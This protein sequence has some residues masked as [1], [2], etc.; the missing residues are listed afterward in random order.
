MRKLLLGLLLLSGCSATL[1]PL[2]TAPDAQTFDEKLK[3]HGPVE[4]GEVS[5]LK[6]EA[7]GRDLG[8]AR[9]AASLLSLSR[10]AEAEQTL[11]SLGSTTTDPA[12]WATA[13]ASRLLKEQL[14]QGAFPKSLERSDMI[15][16]GLQSAES[17]IY[18]TSFRLATRLKLPELQA[19]IPKALNSQDSETQALAV[20]A[21]T[22]A[23]AKE[24]LPELQAR[25]KEAD[26]A[27]FPQMAT[28][29]VETRDQAAWEVV[30]Q[31][32]L[33]H[34]RDSGAQLGFIN[35]VNFHMTPAIYAFMVDRAGRKDKFAEQAYFVLVT[36]VV[37]ET[38]PCDHFLM[39]LTL[40]R[41]KQ[42][43][44]TGKREDEPEILVTVVSQGGNPS[45]SR[46]EWEKRLHGQAAV[47]FAEKWLSEHR[48]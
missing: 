44:K 48:K 45:K 13:A 31:S 16:Q 47:D 3:I 25:L 34:A 17:K 18:Q 21:L 14:G 33:E 39:A 26:Y 6:R 32:W 20:A 27:T 28:A 23:Q 15:R 1:E 37:Q 42:A 24:R 2:L 29:L 40:P 5:T 9:N 8:R 12:I 38:Y 11:E 41:L 36:Q 19:E 22:P 35:H 4:A 10:E 30:V 7:R 43:A 46:P